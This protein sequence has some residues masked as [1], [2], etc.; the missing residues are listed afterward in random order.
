MRSGSRV[1]SSPDHT[2]AP[3]RDA[4]PH[5]ELRESAAN[6]S[7]S[8]AFQCVFTVSDLLRGLEEGLA[9]LD[10][11]HLAL[12]PEADRKGTRC[13][14]FISKRKAE[15]RSNQHRERQK[16]KACCNSPSFCRS[17]S[18]AAAS[19]RACSA[20]CFELISSSTSCGT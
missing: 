6:D 9:V 11:D 19:R 3:I 15:K 4:R 7:F 17:S 1:H 20:A 14:R 13:D 16:N 10:P 12:V 8:A 2:I 18:A 5:Q